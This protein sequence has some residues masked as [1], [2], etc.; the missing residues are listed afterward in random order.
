MVILY[1]IING[2]KVNLGVESEEAPFVIKADMYIV[3]ETLS[4]YYDV[5]FIQ[6]GCHYRRLESI[7]SSN[8]LKY[9]AT[10]VVP[11]LLLVDRGLV[12]VEKAKM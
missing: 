4:S 3:P 12:S 1:C 11:N 2:R 10:A 8:T 7:E 5:T 6:C 9:K